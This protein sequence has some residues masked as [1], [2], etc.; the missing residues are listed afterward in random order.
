MK[1]VFDFRSSDASLVDF[2]WHTQ[3][4]GGGTFISSA[5]SNM[6][7]VI[8]RHQGGISVT[9][10]GPETRASTAP[11][12]EDAE[13]LGI[14]FKLGTFMPYLPASEFI[15][16]GINLPDAG[17]KSFWLHGSA[18]QFPD[19]EN[20]DTFV[21]RLI[22]QGLLAYEPIV[23]VALQ[24]Q[25]N[26]LSA[27]SIQRRFLRATGVTH[28]TMYQIERARHAMRLLEEGISILD[29]VEKA[30]YYDQPHLTRSLKHLIGQTPAQIANNR[31]NE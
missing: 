7:M 17:S 6:E 10:R 22:R 19:Y 18:W 1:F 3:S 28:G 11:V 13:F 4:I 15:N 20:I 29:T 12:P 31:S 24:G 5:S 9:V 27:R 16:K 26:D 14:T 21:E 25:L 30:G 8:T 23:G 2:V